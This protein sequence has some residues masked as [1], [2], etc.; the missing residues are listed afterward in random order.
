[1]GHDGAAGG[2]IYFG[3]LPVFRDCFTSFAMTVQSRYMVSRDAV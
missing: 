3:F 2:S 1:M